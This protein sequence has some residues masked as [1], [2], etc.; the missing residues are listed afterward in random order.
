MDQPLAFDSD[1]SLDPLEMVE[2]ILTDEGLNFERTKDGELTF[3]LSGDWKS[4]DMWFVWRPEGECLQL[5]CGLDIGFKPEHVT[6]LYELLSLVNQRVW[7]G[8]FEIYREP[9]MDD[10]EPVNDIVFRHTLAFTTLD[11]PSAVQTAHMINSAADAVDRFF[12]AFDFY[13]KGA[14]SPLAALEACLFETVGE[15]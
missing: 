9:G 1:F 3:M 11:K 10:A 5:C 4:Y 12:P 6:G 13:L 8:H 14:R 15:A 2:T 7:F